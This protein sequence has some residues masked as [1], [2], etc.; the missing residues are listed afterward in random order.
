MS[1][2]L[3]RSSL[4]GMLAEIATAARLPEPDRPRAVAEAIGGFSADPVLLEGVR[5]P[6]SEDRYARH[7]LAEDV[8]GGYAVAALVWRPGQM[9]RVHSH[10]VWCAL[11]VHAGVL[12]ETLY[13]PCGPD[14]LPEPA[15]SL[16]RGR[17]AVSYGPADPTLI[18][19]IANLGCRMAI[20]IHVYGLRFEDFPTGVNQILSA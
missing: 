11:G 1:A 4:T 9:S 19:R 12:T 16:L 20:S 14:E 2:A 6:C 5:C 17:G 8:D 7:L 10:R 3:T 18:H 15:A 13:D